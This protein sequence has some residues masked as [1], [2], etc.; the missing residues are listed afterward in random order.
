MVA[1]RRRS[2][3]RSSAAQARVTSPAAKRP[4]TAR[5]S[6]PPRHHPERP[7][8]RARPTRTFL[9]GDRAFPDLCATGAPAR[10]RGRDVPEPVPQAGLVLRRGLSY[11]GGVSR[12]CCLAPWRRAS[13]R[14]PPRSAP[15][16]S[17]AKKAEAQQVYAQ[18]LALDQNLGAADERIN[19]ANLRLAQVEYQQ[20]V[21]RR[22]LI[23]AKRN[24]AQSRQLIAKRLVSIY[25]TTQPSTLDMILGSTSLSDLMTRLDNADRLSRLDGQVIGQVVTFKAAVLR[26]RT[27]AQARAHLR[28]RS[29]RPAPG[30]A[31]LGRRRTRRARAV[32]DLDQGRDLDARGAGG[33]ASA[34]E[35]RATQ[36]AQVAAAQAAQQQAAQATVVG[37]SAATPEGATSCPPRPTAARSSRSRCRTSAPRTSGA[38][39]RR[40]AST[41]PGLVMYSFAQLGHLAAALLVRAV[42]LRQPVAYSDL[43]PGD[44]VFFDGARARRALHRRRRV[45]R[46]A[47]HG[48]VRP[49]RQPHER[50]GA[51]ALL[52]RTPDHRPV[53]R[54]IHP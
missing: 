32:A 29:R 9:Q 31:A 22:E 49:S 46:R 12:C 51:L 25:T 2:G 16:R 48:C 1:R 18:I 44:L 23:V 15:R 41:A 5:T 4:S 19:L 17:T 20:K 8:R 43:Q 34:P 39:R 47:V 11:K 45:R 50:L 7:Y 37:A 35:A 30:R 52:R 13:S 10:L 54:R 3:S 6:A 28:R 27:P 53:E 33:G 24:L 26:A 36:Q 21:N 40:A 14:P 42:E 38:A